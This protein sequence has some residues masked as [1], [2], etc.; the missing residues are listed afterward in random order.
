MGLALM[1]SVVFN[2]CFLIALVCMG[3]QE[4]AMPPY[5]P[6]KP[7]RRGG[8]C[9]RNGTTASSSRPEFARDVGSRILESLK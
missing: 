6:E 7:V 1:V 2:I 8:M 9:S 5:D 4:E 3:S